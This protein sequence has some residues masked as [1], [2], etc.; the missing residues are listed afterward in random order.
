MV[1]LLNARVMP[2]ID[3]T[4]GIYYSKQIVADEFGLELKAANKSGEL[5][6]YIG[7]ESTAKVIQST[8]D[9]MVD[10]NRKDAEIVTGDILLMIYLQGRPPIERDAI[11]TDFKFAIGIYAD[12]LI[13]LTKGINLI[14]SHWHATLGCNPTFRDEEHLLKHCINKEN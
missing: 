13:Y 2:R 7:H 14:K 10:V 11:L 4:G 12:D 3:W 5:R 8:W 9:V 6:S 1:I